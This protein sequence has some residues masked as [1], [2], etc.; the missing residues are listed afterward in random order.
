[1]AASAGRIAAVAS[2]VAV[3]PAHTALAS[4]ERLEILTDPVLVMF[5]MII[6]L[7]LAAEE[8]SPKAFF[9]SG[10]NGASN[11]HPEKMELI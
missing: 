11:A 9:Q 5:V 4:K 3:P 2:I 10:C 8:D 7:T 6:V 1:M